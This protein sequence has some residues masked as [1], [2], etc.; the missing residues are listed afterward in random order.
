VTKAGLKPKV[1]KV[2]S[3]SVKAGV[4][5]QTNPQFGVKV[6]PGST[7]TL[8]VSTGPKQ[9]KMPPVTGESEA[10]A[11]SQL[12]QFRVTTKTDPNSAKPAGTV[13]RQSPKAGTMLLPNSP[14]TIWVSGG[15][16]QVQNTVGDPK[17]TAMSILQ[18][19]GFKVQVI[20]TA[21]PSSA[22]PG[23]VFQQTPS[24]GV[25]PQGSTVTIYVASTPTPTQSATTPPPTPTPSATTPT[26]TPTGTATLGATSSSRTP[27][28]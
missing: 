21:G 8:D 17:A 23:N 10:T 25:L 13:V 12:Q 24:S 19:A 7:V 16:T 28:P 14:V 11:Q 1:V 22:T 9:I 4:V 5:T 3:P 2:P 18:N 20:T 27:R 6:A 15:G 26:P